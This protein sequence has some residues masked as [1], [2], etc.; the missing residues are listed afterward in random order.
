MHATLAAIVLIV[1]LGLSGCAGANR[2]AHSVQ[3]TDQR[4]EYARVVMGSR[5]RLVVYARD[6]PVD[7]VQ[8][9]FSIL[10]ECD[11][12]LSDYNP[13]SEARQLTD[14][15]HGVWRPASPLLIYA[16]VLSQSVFNASDGAFDITVGP[17]TSLWRSANAEGRAPEI[18]ELEGAR[19]R[20]GMDLVDID[21]RTR[22]VRLNER[23]MRFDFGAIGKGMAADLALAELER[24]GY[25]VAMVEI[26][27][28]LVVGAPPPG[29]D[30]WVIGVSDGTVP[31][32]VVRLANQ[33]I[34][35]SGSTYRFYELDGTA[36]SHV[37]D[38]STAQPIAQ[39][40][41]VAV[42]A[43]AGWLA[44]AIATLVAL[45]GPEDASDAGSSLGEVR[46]IH[47][48][49]HTGSASSR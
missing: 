2:A 6:E 7:A 23:S 43:H 14:A 10:D 17:V 19:T 38:P 48:E 13:N 49:E 29:R 44:D 5:A 47:V 16:L 41:A 40:P 31:G 25:N 20:V 3:T 8:R 39:T 28:D 36:I 11:D 27:G 42:V 15:P 37:I 9:A 34:A 26:G 18:G 46:L 24:S 12:T 1:T 45:V 30:G 32:P 21:E 4:F 33:A 22:R 35:T